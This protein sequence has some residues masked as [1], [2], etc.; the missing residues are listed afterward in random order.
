MRIE[1]FRKILNKSLQE[2]GDIREKNLSKN[3]IIKISQELDKHIVKE[4]K[5]R[6]LNII[7][8]QEKSKL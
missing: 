8:N 1:K 3:N 2:M 5:R 6:L 4:Q 7:S